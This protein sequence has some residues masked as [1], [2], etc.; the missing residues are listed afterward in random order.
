VLA[1]AESVMGQDGRALQTERIVDRRRM[2][3]VMA[4]EI[5]GKG[6]SVEST[7]PEMN[8]ATASVS[9]SRR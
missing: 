2:G 6:A 9:S 7:S 1:A 3:H 5:S 4:N 8:H